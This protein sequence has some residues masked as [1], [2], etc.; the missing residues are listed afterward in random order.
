MKSRCG[1]LLLGVM[2]L[3]GCYRA[4]ICK[5]VT[6]P[7]HMVQSTPAVHLIAHPAIPEIIPGGQ[8]AS[9]R[10]VWIPEH[11]QRQCRHEW[12]LGE[13]PSLA[14]QSTDPA[15]P[16]TEQSGNEQDGSQ[17]AP[18][19]SQSPPGGEEASLQSLPP[20]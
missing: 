9:V 15:S 7:A 14:A 2:S 12:R 19:P 3:V 1:F 11:V 8:T 17:P 6:I 13:A 18:A 10:A 5:D 16:T 20:Q 4:E